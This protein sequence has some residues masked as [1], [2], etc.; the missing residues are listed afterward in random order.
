MK[1]EKEYLKEKGWR[2]IESDLWDRPGSFLD[3]KNRKNLVNT[4]DAI[5][6]QE[7]IDK[8]QYDT[9]DNLRG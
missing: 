6:L 4:E 9:V 3:T 8:W 2:E 5:K 7:M 1:E